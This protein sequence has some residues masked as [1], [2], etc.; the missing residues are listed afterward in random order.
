M[1]DF[2]N[3]IIKMLIFCNVNMFRRNV[4]IDIVS[5]NN[6]VFKSKIVEVLVVNMKVMVLVEFW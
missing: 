5:L 4:D 3:F 1:G 6:L 2:C